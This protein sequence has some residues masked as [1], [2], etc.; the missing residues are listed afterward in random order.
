VRLGVVTKEEDIFHV[1]VRMNS[2]DTLLQF[3][4][5]LLIL[6]L[7]CTKVEAGNFTTIYSVLH[8]ISKS[9]LKMIKTL[10]GE[11]LWLQT[12]YESSMYI[13]LLLHFLIKNWRHHFCTVPRP[14][15]AS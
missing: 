12:I 4:W 7:M 6:L 15:T 14:C 1:S 9:V 2:M 8:S 10:W 5:S 13:S 11:A 3:V